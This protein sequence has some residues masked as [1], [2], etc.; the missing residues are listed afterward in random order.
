MFWGGLLSI[1]PH[2]DA[3]HFI[4]EKYHTMYGENAELP[5]NL[6]GH[7]PMALAALAEWSMEY[8]KDKDKSFLGTPLPDQQRGAFWDVIRA[9]ADESEMPAQ[10]IKMEDYTCCRFSSATL[11][12]SV[13]DG[14]NDQG[15]VTEFVGES[16]L[17]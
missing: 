2:K 8:S 6:S 5:V 16:V 9:H 12:I 14:N 4:E 15:F 3:F 7:S 11:F 10:R 1:L 13:C 17:S